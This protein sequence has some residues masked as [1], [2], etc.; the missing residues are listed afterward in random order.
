GSP[1]TRASRPPLTRMPSMRQ[2]PH[3]DSGTAMNHRLIC[4]N[5]HEWELSIGPTDGTMEAAPL[6]PTCGAAGQTRS[7]ADAGSAPT[8]NF[9]GDP[10]GEKVSDA[11]RP[12]IP[13]H[14]LV[15]E[16]GR[17]GMGVVYLARQTQLN[18]LVALKMI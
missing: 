8:L 6:C 12:V 11:A 18:R 3:Q 16:L 5:G 14:E 17:G 7:A 1:G 15:R 4:P 2:S 9:E 13:G 10:A